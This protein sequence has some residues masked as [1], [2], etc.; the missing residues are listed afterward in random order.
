MNNKS[1]VYRWNLATLILLNII[2][3]S[4]RPI[5]INSSS[6]PIEPGQYSVLGSAEGTSCYKK[7]LGLFPTSN[8]LPSIEKAIQRAKNVYPNTDA[9]I[10]MS[11]DE[12]NEFWF[13]YSKSCTVVKGQAVQVN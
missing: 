9:L 6:I 1:K 12:Y 5:A 4:S 11:V 10:E 8:A 7:F 13:F 2:G 3:C